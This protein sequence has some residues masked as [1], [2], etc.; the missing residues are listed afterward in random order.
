MLDTKNNNEFFIK[1]EELFFFINRSVFNFKLKVYS[2]IIAGGK[3]SLFLTKFMR[4]LHTARDI[5]VKFDWNIF[6]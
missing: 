3:F 4:E 1:L 5:A 6:L 2:L